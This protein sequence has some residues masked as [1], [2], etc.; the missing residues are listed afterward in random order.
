MENAIS[1]K[2]FQDYTNFLNLELNKYGL[3]LN[4]Q[5]KTPTDI[6]LAYFNWQK[7][8]ISS[9]PRKVYISNELQCP[10]HLKSAFENLIESLKNGKDVTGYLSR[11]I[12]HVSRHDFLLYDWGIHHLHF[13]D[14]NITKKRSGELLY[15]FFNQNSAYLLDIKN[16]DSFADTDLLEILDSNW[17]HITDPLWI[18]NAIGL[19][20]KVTDKDRIILRKANINVPVVLK[21]RK[22]LMSMF[23]GEGITSS[24]D[25]SYSSNKLLDIQRAFDDIGE[26]IE[27]VIT[28]NID[29]ALE[30]IFN[31]HSKFYLAQSDN[32]GWCIFNPKTDIHIT[33]DDLQNKIH[34]HKNIEV[35]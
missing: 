14:F 11:N 32:F 13:Y 27:K 28:H 3:K 29:I 6:A 12:N 22:C 18:K 5:K 1:K 35:Y 7:K 17:S 9:T 34:L 20:Q 8:L 30:P 23:L 24:G 25:S 31:K 15:V 4:A 2:L 16:H 33:L 19:S 10:T 21:N 26:Y